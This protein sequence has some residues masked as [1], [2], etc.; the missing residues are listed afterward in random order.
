LFT[1]TSYPR[2][3]ITVVSGVL[4]AVLAASSPLCA[5]GF[6]SDGHIIRLG[7]GGGVTVPISDAGDAFKSGVNG[8]GFVLVQLPGLPALRF[9]LSYDRFSI[10]PTLA[11]PA[12]AGEDE[13]GHSQILGGVAGLKIHL[14]PG[15][16][17]PYVM[18]GVGAFNVNDLV[19]LSTGTTSTS[20]TNF[21]VDGGAGIEVK[22]GRLAAFAE[23]RLQNVYTRNSGLVAKSS[24][25]SVPVNFGLLF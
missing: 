20:T 25:K 6:G 9:A 2:V 17:R 19:N 5:Q 10:K 21:G 23:G 1:T 11:N 22:L 8:Q 7:F 18:A 13:A 12:A 4:L 16:V 24:I 15:P 3:A 14:L